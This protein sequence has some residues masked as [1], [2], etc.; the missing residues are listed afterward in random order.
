MD[1]DTRALL[2][3]ATQAARRTLEDELRAQLEGVYDIRPDGAVA[4]EAGRHLAEDGAALRVRTRLVAAVDHHRASGRRPAEAV[5]ALLREHAFHHPQPPRGAQDVG[6]PEIVKPCV[7]QGPLS[8]GF[9]EFI[10][11]APGLVALPDQGYRLYLDS[12]FD[13]I[14]RE[15]RVLF[16]RR[17]PASLLWPRKPA[18]DAV[19]GIL[20]DP[21][22]AGVWGEDETI[23][24]VYQY[25]NGEDRAPPDAPREPGP[26]NSRKF[27]VRNQFFTPA[28]SS[29][30]PHRQHPRAHLGRAAPGRHPP[31]RDLPLSGAAP[32]RDLRRGRRPG[33]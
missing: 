31:R 32:W 16:D 18:L 5:A 22:L 9:R 25:F 17:D 1:K 27:A 30:V 11:L 12:L 4:A 6:G 8:G 2:Q 13:E 26:R 24:W 33:R 21:A 14:G 23:G 15:V 29:R 10:G 28:T 3:R 19:L 20:N 7:S